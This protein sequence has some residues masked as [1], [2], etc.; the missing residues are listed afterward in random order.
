MFQTTR[1]LTFRAIIVFGSLGAAP[2]FAEAADL[3]PYRQAPR[4]PAYIPAQPPPP[5]PMDDNGPAIGIWTGAYW[6]LSAGYGWGTSDL[7]YDRANHGATFT[8][9]EGALGAITL[10]YNHQLPSGLTLGIEGDLGIMDLTASDKTVF[11]GHTFQSDY[12]T[13][14]G[15]IRGRVGVAM[16]RTLFYGTGGLAFMDLEEQALGNTAGETALNEDFKTGWV[17]GGGIEHALSQNMTLK[18]EYLHMDFGR[19]EGVSA[20]N[21]AFS[22]E[23]KVDLVRAGVNFKF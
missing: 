18:V 14:W 17:A 19:F 2:A 11:D 22:F 21:E 20:G 16:G 1:T 23:N 12:G 9:P 10:G 13:W 15:T 3:G 7:S 6:G 8:E 5:P 4:S